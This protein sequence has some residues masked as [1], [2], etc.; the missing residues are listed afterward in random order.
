MVTGWVFQSTGV[1]QVKKDIEK[2]CNFA[3]KC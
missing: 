2:P 1:L 3:K